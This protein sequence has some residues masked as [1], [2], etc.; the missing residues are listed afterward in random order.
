MENSMTAP[1]QPL[2]ILND[3]EISLERAS[4]VKRFLNYIIDF[5][6]FFFLY[7]FCVGVLIGLG[8]VQAEY[9]ES[10][11][12]LLFLACYGT[13]MGLLEFTFKGKT[14]GKLITGT[15][16]VNEDGSRISFKM[17]MLRGYSR[18][19]PLEPL[20]A[21]GGNPFHDQWTHTLVIDEK[22]SFIPKK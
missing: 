18:L 22:K 16:A 14:L 1:E 5:A 4:V 3:L 17:A 13:W 2:D 7:Y 10:L 6:P 11:T 19:V 12:Y 15:R 20:S 21:F 9:N 8:V